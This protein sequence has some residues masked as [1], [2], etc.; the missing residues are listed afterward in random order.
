[1]DP[2]D[3]GTHTNLAR[4]CLE[5][6]DLAAAEEHAKAAVALRDQDEAALFV[7]GKV[8]L[9]EGKLDEATATFARIAAS[10]GRASSA[11]YGTAMVLARRG[12][13]AG[14]LAKLQEATA[15]KVPNPQ[16]IADDPAFA[17]MKDD[18]AFSRIVTLASK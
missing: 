5:Q 3:V 15:L 17:S 4:V 11:P 7:L 9:A 18:P 13:K 16:E 12:D 10:N 2:T 1:L 6:G 14:A 8:M